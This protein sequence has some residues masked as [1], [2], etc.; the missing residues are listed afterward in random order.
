MHLRHVL[1]LPFG[2][3]NDNVAALQHDFPKAAV[4]SGLK[5]RHPN[6]TFA[7]NVSDVSVA[8]GT[9]NRLR[10]RFALNNMAD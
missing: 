3:S 7:A 2:Q 10:A 5:G 4:H 1:P 9:D 6:R 8:D